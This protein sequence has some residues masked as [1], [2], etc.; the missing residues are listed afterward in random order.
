MQDIA[1]VAGVMRTPLVVVVHPSVP[2]KTISEFIAHAKANPGKINMGSGGDGTPS[3]ASGELFKMMAGVDLVHV[4]Y[5]GLS[6]ALTDLLGGQGNAPHCFPR[7]ADRIGLR[8]RSASRHSGRGSVGEAAA[9]L[10][11][12]RSYPGVAEQGAARINS[13][14]GVSRALRGIASLT[15]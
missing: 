13:P 7:Y 14:A 10:S 4:P 15:R 1:P 8:V 5:R 3:H 12:S 2:A 6:P 9:R 11:Q